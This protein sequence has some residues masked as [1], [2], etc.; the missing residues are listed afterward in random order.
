MI[1][2][3]TEEMGSPRAISANT[4]PQAPTTKELSSNHER[5][6]LNQNGTPSSSAIKKGK[7][8]TQ[9]RCENDFFIEIQIRL[10]L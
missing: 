4:Q 2:S 6:S 10:L 9:T 7:R 1:D 3:I 5:N 8:T